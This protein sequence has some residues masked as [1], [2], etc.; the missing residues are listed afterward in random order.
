MDHGPLIYKVDNPIKVLRLVPPGDSMNMG[1]GYDDMIGCATCR[2][3]CYLTS[4]L[5][6]PH[7]FI[8]MYASLWTYELVQIV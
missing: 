8:L 6:S 1:Q 2:R 7:V 3:C 5:Q 4:F